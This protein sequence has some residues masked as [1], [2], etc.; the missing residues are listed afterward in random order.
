[1]AATLGD[2]LDVP[3]PIRSIDGMFSLWGCLAPV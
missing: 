2:R 3:A 1:M